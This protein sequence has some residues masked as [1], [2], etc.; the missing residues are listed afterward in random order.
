MNIRTSVQLEDYQGFY[1]HGWMRTLVQ[2]TDNTILEEPIFE[3]AASWKGTS[4]ARRLPWLMMTCLKEYYESMANSYEPTPL[5]AITALI[6]RIHKRIEKHSL[7]FISSDRQALVK[8]FQD[9]ESELVQGLQQNR[10]TYNIQKLWKEFIEAEEFAI[11]LW[12]SEVQ[13]YSSVYFA[14]EIFLI[15][16]VKILTNQTRLRTHQLESELQ[17]LTGSNTLWEFCWN[18][19]VVEKA[20]L[21]RSAIVH[22]GRKI[23]RDLEKYRS[24]LALEDEEIVIMPNDTNQLYVELK[25]RITQFCES[26]IP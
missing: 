7:S 4:N 3:L 26:F 12:M 21:V 11:S 5:T 15:S 2:L 10:I 1:D 14:Y 25:D 24:A 22:N 19:E 20:R 13:A 6:D 9:I 8:E 16:S 23:T 17:G 18:H